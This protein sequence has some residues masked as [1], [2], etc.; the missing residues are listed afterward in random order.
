[1]K[2]IILDTNAY[3]RFLVGDEKVLDALSTSETIYMCI[4]VLGKLYAG[5]YGGN[6]ENKNREI[7]QR[8][9]LKPPVKIL[10]AGVETAEIFGQLKNTLK[11]AGKPLPI[12][13]VWIAAQTLETGSILITYD[14]HFQCVPGLRLWSTLVK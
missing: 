1:M 13:D 11:Q 8:F 5:F 6:K 7:L 12:N 2:K 10:H 9:L 4:F 14:L 3:S